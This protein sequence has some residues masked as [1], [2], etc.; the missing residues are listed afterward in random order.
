MANGIKYM[1]FKSSS[2]CFVG[3]FVHQQRMAAL[4]AGPAPAQG[5]PVQGYRMEE[6]KMEPI[7]SQTQI[8]AEQ[9][10]VQQQNMA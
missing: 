6:H 9:Q 8:P 4:S 10:H 2:N 3:I 5:A 7:T 1:C